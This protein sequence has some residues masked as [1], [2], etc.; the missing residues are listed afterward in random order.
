LF[1]M[2]TMGVANAVVDPWSDTSRLVD[3][4]LGPR[5][6]SLSAS[7]PSL[8]FGNLS[9]SGSVS[10]NKQMEQ[11]DLTVCIQYKEPLLPE[12]V[13]WQDHRCSPVSRFN[14]SGAS[15]TVNAPCITGTWDYRTK[16]VG[17]AYK[18]GED[19][20]TGIRVTQPPVRYTCPINIG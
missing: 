9:A 12:N 3:D 15:T 16:A 8:S 11:I 10:C 6:C 7:S 4:L 17:A 13:T 20:W 5:A 18:G 19:P 1:L 14:V 2:P